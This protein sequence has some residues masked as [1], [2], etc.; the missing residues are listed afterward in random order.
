VSFIKEI[1]EKL[2]RFKLKKEKKRLQ[3]KVKAFSLEN[4]STVGVLYNATNRNDAEIVK[5][6]IHYL[7]EERKEVHSLGFVDAKES[8]EL[9]KPILNYTFFDQN[10]LAK[11]LVPNGNEVVNFLNKPFSILI[12]LTT[13]DSCFPLEYISSLSSAKFKVGANGT[14]RAEVC[15]LVIDIDEDPQLEFLISQ[16]KHY[17]KMIKN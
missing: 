9:I 1:Q 11:N 3:R 12:D 7:K 4:A 14:Y 17:L 13:N 15:D 8:S 16:I 6:F 2:G 10:Y 5:K